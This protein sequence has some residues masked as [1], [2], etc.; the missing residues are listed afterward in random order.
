M[1][2]NKIRKIVLGELE[3]LNDIRK[4]I[5]EIVEVIN[6]LLIEGEIDKRI[7]KI[8]S[9]QEKIDKRLEKIEERLRK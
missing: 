2:F 1:P 7:D 8:K 3:T 6:L 9:N 4:T 5:E